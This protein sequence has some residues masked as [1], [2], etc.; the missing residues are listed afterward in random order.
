MS[1]VLIFYHKGFAHNTTI[2]LIFHTTNDNFSRESAL[3]LHLS[4]YILLLLILLL[5]YTMA[6][7]VFTIISIRSTL[8]FY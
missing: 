5:M 1:G 3:L 4:I 6:A 2:I 7:G 8:V